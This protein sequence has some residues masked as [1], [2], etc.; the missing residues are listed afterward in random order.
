MS[1]ETTT[2]QARGTPVVEAEEIRSYAAGERMTVG[3][4]FAGTW[5][6]RRAVV[7]AMADG[8][9]IDAKWLRAALQD[10]GVPPG[11]AL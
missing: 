3:L 9:R 4:V 1:D 6:F 2:I 8:T 10:A 11:R 7:Q 5:R